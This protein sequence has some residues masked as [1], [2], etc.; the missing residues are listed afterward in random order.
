M[1]YYFIFFKILF[2]F[3]YKQY[4]IMELESG[5]YQNLGVVVVIEE[6]RFYIIII[7]MGKKF[8]GLFFINRFFFKL[9]IFMSICFMILQGK[10]G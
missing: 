5:N 9:K 6:G 10:C 7:G 1:Y 2:V 8:E 4:M 3:F